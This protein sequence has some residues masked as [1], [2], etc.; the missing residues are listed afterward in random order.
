MSDPGIIYLQPECCASPD[1]RRMWCEDPDPVDCEDGKHWTKY[2]RGDEIEQLRAENEALRQKNVGYFGH[3]EDA[4]Q[5]A[6]KYYEE[7]ARLRQREAE[8]MAHVN[9]LRAGLVYAAQQFDT[10]ND[11]DE[12]LATSSAQSLAAH[13]AE[14]AE[15]V[16]MA[17]VNNTD[18]GT[19]WFDADE[20]IAYIRNT[21]IEELLK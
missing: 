21:P 15:L 20:V 17:I 5:Q 12:L 13:D 8:L 14:V 6:E 9:A 1:T 10:W 18:D 2:V 11:Y 19:D 3:A 4:G 7:A 16:R